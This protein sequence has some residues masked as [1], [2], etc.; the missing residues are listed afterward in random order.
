[1]KYLCYQ[2][3]FIFLPFS[4]VSKSSRIF[5]KDS[6]DCI[7]GKITS[8]KCEVIFETKIKSKIVGRILKILPTFAKNIRKYF[9]IY[10]NIF[11]IIYFIL[12]ISIL[13]KMYSIIKINFY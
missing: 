10:F 6:I 8:K 7:L 2:G 9:R 13:I 5:F 3:F 11:F 1:M 12:L 4:L